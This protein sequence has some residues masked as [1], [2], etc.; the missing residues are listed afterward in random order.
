MLQRAVDKYWL[1]TANGAID[2][3]SD[4]CYCLPCGEPTRF[5]SGNEVYA[6]AELFWQRSL[7]A[8]GGAEATPEKAS[9]V[10]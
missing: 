5:L 2:F 1:Q 8:L 10:S 6:V 4:E 7:Q 9:D 3:E